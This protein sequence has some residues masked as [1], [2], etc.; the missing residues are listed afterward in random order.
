MPKKP[1]QQEASPPEDQLTKLPS[2]IL[3]MIFDYLFCQHKPDKAF[4]N[5]NPTNSD[6]ILT[7][8]C[9]HDLDYVS[10][11]SR[12][13]RAEVNEWAIHWLTTHESIT[14]FKLPKT[15]N[16]SRTFNML[17]S[18]KGLLTWAKNHCIFCGRSSVRRAIMMNGFK[19]CSKCDAKEWPDKLTKTTAQKQYGLKEHHLF[20]RLRD[21]TTKDRIV[22]KSPLPKIRYGTYTCAGGVATTNFLRK[23]VEKLATALHGDLDAYFEK[24]KANLE[25][26]RRRLAEKWETRKAVVG[27][28]YEN[29]VPLD[30]DDWSH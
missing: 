4:D 7:A 13:L 26:R 16:K 17:R 20:P 29:P 12:I 27:D 5:L 14:N 30:G 28:A 22:P 24:R 25:E 2:E 6:D 1:P 11:T 23:D 10:A 19:C 8:T 15:T 18:R 3:H 9:N 21:S